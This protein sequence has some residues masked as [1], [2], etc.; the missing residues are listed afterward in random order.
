MPRPSQPAPEPTP[1]LR[2]VPVASVASGRV[3]A[4]PIVR[5][6]VA[7]VAGLRAGEAWASTIVEAS[8]DA[9]ATLLVNLQ[10]LFD[11]PVIVIGGGVG[12]AEG[13]LDKL[14]S[15]VDRQP[16]LCRPVLRLAAL[17]RHAG[18]IGAADLAASA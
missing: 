18:V 15:R 17:G 4:L 13:Y 2:P 3:R 5:D 7:L 9:V 14:R 8:A 11:P 16:S 10:L 12:L 1:P 6:D